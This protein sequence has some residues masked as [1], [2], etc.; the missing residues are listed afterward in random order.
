MSKKAV[1]LSSIFL[2]I[3]LLFWG[4]NLTYAQTQEWPI[5]ELPRESQILEGQTLGNVLLTIFT[6]VLK[7]LTWLAGAFAVLWIIW[8]GIQVIAQAKIDEG[9]NRLIFGAVGLTIALLAWAITKFIERLVIEGQ[10]GI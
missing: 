5:G 7:I 8:G 10:V 3:L 9:K 4:L 6:W 2:T 1:K